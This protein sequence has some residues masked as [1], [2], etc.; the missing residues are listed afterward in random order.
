MDV[1]NLIISLVSGIV[2]GNVVSATM[3]DKFLGTVGN[4]ITGL[5][6]GGIGH[7]ILQ[8]L[9]LFTT[10][11]VTHATGNSQPEVVQHGLDLGTLLG[12][13]A[14]SGVCGA[15]LTALAAWIKTTANK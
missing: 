8:A 4:S 5:L 2:G 6:G 1:V 11:A 12:N 7:Y 14:G 9:G 13:V 10:I 15:V 3:P